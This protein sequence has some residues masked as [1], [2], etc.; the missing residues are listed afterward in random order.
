MTTQ[1][2]PETKHLKYTFNVKPPYGLRGSASLPQWDELRDVLTAIAEGATPLNGWT[3]IKLTDGRARNA[4]GVIYFHWRNLYSG[5][6]WSFSTRVADENTLY[7]TRVP[8]RERTI[9]VKKSLA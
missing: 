4:T 3:E 5:M 6:D 2:F 7:I 8:R 9:K 1:I